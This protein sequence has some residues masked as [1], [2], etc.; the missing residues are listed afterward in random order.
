MLL[1]F[2]VLNLIQ[3]CIKFNLDWTAF[4]RS[5]FTYRIGL[6]ASAES[7]T[8]SGK[9]RVRPFRTDQDRTGA[10]LEGLWKTRT[11]FLLIASRMN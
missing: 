10:R 7:M 5:L 11:S 6:V 2:S 8:Y 4:I 1:M 9:N 3:T